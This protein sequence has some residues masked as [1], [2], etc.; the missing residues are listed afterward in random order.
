MA[1]LSPINRKGV[2]MEHL[3]RKRIA[4]IIYLVFSFIITV[5][6]TI[7]SCLFT[8][9]EERFVNADEQVESVV[10]T[11]DSMLEKRAYAQGGV[12][13]DLVSRARLY[14]SAAA[15]VDPESLEPK[16]YGSGYIIRAEGADLSVPEGFPED[17]RV[18]ADS[19]T[20][21]HDAD[22]TG[23]VPF[24]YAHISGPFYYLE[25]IDGEA[26]AALGADAADP[27]SVLSGMAAAN[28]CDYIYVQKGSLSADSAI[29]AATNDYRGDKT[30][31]DT[32][33]TRGKIRALERRGSTAAW[34][35]GGAKWIMRAQ[36]LSEDAYGDV[37]IVVDV[38]R[39]LL[40][41]VQQSTMIM[42]I[43]MI[44]LITLSVW[45]FSVYETVMDKILDADE[46]QAYNP[47][48]MRR[49]MV[50]I[51][52]IASLI[53]FAM[54]TAI[55]SLNCIFAKTSREENV[56]EQYVAKIQDDER[57]AGAA[58]QY[59]QSRYISAADQ[60]A[61]LIEENRD[62]QNAAWL[63][64]AADIIS[65]DY[66][67]IYDA[68]G[69]EVVSGSRYRG[70]SLGKNE[71]SAT[72]DFRRLLRGVSSIS[73][74]GVTDE[75]T[76]LTRD[77]HG[78]SLRYLSNA[79]AYGAL[80]IAVDPDRQETVPVSDTDETAAAM[81]PA[82]GF[83]MGV[84]PGTG[85][86][87]CSSIE[88]Y[89]GA[90]MHAICKDLESY[91][92]SFM[93]VADIGST[94][95]YLRSIE[96][97][98]IIYYCGIDRQEMFNPV[99]PRSFDTAIIFLFIAAVLAVILLYGYNQKVFDE[100]A[101]QSV[102]PSE[103][104]LGRRAKGALR[105]QPFASANLSRKQ[106][107]FMKN[108]YF[109]FLSK[110]QGP[111]ER[112][113]SA[114][115]ILILIFT[116]LIVIYILIDT[117]GSHDSAGGNDIIKYIVD[118]DWQRGLNMFAIAAIVLLASILV[119]IIYLLR[120]IAGTMYKYVD[121]KARTTMMLVM[122]AVNYLAIIVF[123]FVSMGY[124]G[125]DTNTLLASAGLAGVA[126][127]LGARDLI[128]D[129]LSGIMILADNTFT[130]GDIISVSG[131]RGEVAEIGMR[132][133]RIIGRGDNVKSIR[134]SLLGDVTNYSRLNSWYPLLLS[135]RSTQ[136]L[137]DLESMLNEKLPEITKKYPE[138]ISGPEYRGVES[139]D[140]DITTILILT[141]CK[142]G[143]YN[144]VQR[145]VNHEVRRLLKDNQI[146]L[147]SGIET[148]DKAKSAN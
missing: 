101:N 27:G 142:E 6:V 92:G 112:V 18:S 60:I 9:L 59:S 71:K 46:R 114:A 96:H 76:G 54:S 69:D 8:E 81:S 146:E 75:M 2:H 97:D 61:A 82:N 3:R 78:V 105:N 32:G 145:N 58:W 65:A 140:G 1:V 79:Q 51:L 55:I 17:L 107:E 66:I 134:N 141:E 16:A 62:L 86:V 113:R 47:K 80:I 21:E 31:S 10:R 37:L 40:G 19:F 28:D 56:L 103:S 29:Y 41:P 49:N 63:R 45:V 57:K 68:G 34:I 88:S 95:Y 30:I 22:L 15:Q 106:T 127:S 13:D 64:Q 115:Q 128:S 20:A 100:Y 26:P 110:G 87:T 120:L 50:A 93:G 102:T 126:L 94:E 121:T 38:R 90:D 148:T 48:S 139:I 133:T 111:T 130:V 67:M 25:S 7:G 109:G 117:A 143:D 44:M 85:I 84:D 35:K 98:G 138:I 73:H 125:V 124:I 104:F 122:N 24:I 136:S 118:G 77:M 33:L 53:L 43:V 91:A 119:V 74:A 36:P 132:S 116:V 99:L 70:M 123:T 5:S 72:Y 11:Y 131:F 144:S 39:I 14:A 135:I 83:I 52:L 108:S 4:V 12:K 23:D 42:I 129:V 89:R 137:S 147:M